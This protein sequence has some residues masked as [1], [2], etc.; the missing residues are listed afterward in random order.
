MSKNKSGNVKR[1]STKLYKK[2]INLGSLILKLSSK[3]LAWIFIRLVIMFFCIFLTSIIYFYYKLPPYEDLL[4]GRE[5][6][7]V[8]LLDRNNENFAWRGDQFDRS[9]TSENAN[10]N[11]INAII[12]TED[13]GFYKHFGVSIRGILGAIRINLLEGRGPFSGHGGS[14]ITQQVAKLL[15][16]LNEKNKSES[17]CR[18]R[19]LTRKI[20][21]VPFALAL[22]IKFTKSNILSIY[23]NRVYLG[24]GATGFEAASQ[25]YFNKSAKNVNVSEAAMLASLLSAPSRYAPTSNLKRAQNRSKIV[26]RSMANQNF[27]TKSQVDLALK[28]PANLSKNANLA[29]G[30]HFADWVM[31]QAP[32]SLTL[33]TTEDILISTTFDPEVQIAVHE[34]ISKVFKTKIKKDSRAE[35]AVV[36]MR[37][38]G[39]VVAMLGGRNSQNLTGQFN[40]ATQSL[41]Q[42]G[43]AF[44]PFVYVTALEFGYS[45]NF[46]IK[47]KRVEFQDSISRVYTPKNYRDQYFGNISLTEALAKSANSVAVQL[48]SKVGPEN[49]KEIAQKLGIKSRIGSNLA[50]ALGSSE[51]SLID[52]T[53]SYAGFLNL[54]RRVDPV[55]WYDL[56]LRDSNEILMKSQNLPG[57]RAISVHSSR[58]LITMLRQ[59]ILSG[60]GGDAQILD[61][62]IAGKTG[63]SQNSKD[64][65]FVGFT[66]KY[67]TGV[68]VGYDDNTPLKGVTGG[69]IPAQIWKRIMLEIHKEQPDSLP[70]IKS[71]TFNQF[72]SLNSHEKPFLK[73]EEISGNFL[74]RMLKFFSSD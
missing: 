52:L 48:A 59:V 72:F 62:D 24:A 12:A 16:L 50:I 18:K 70:I 13:R 29:I 30:S 67:I 57:V 60:T 6:G 45:P 33:N 26:I 38:N 71:D 19:S 3:I 55:G 34:S 28:Q 27:L 31:S 63:T 69:N 36:V 58:A 51:V 1:S 15:C 54:G 22:E 4:D 41:R 2:G 43:S 14:T 74:E 20:L 49:V 10:K 5:R 56:R 73:K 35:V 11:L 21:E 47:D 8:T 7:S 37:P 25:R 23:L 53:S 42:P 9:L 17:E 40:R 68:W 65:W 61:W 64:A 44:K 39:E 46:M 32:N 66:S